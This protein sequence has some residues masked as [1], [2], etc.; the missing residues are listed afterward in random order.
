MI[1]CNRN[2]DLNLVPSY[3]S[4][5]LNYKII[6]I[7]NNQ[8]SKI[9]SF[10]INKNVVENLRIKFL[11]VLYFNMNQFTCISLPRSMN[12][13]ITLYKNTAF[14]YS[15][16]EVKMFNQVKQKQNILR[17]GKNTQKNCTKKIFM[18]QIIT[19]V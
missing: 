18:T 4:V 14:L 19:M 3:F 7:F 1:L 10:P 9:L 13:N 8:H 12:S 6:L 16:S 2:E 5:R 11:S 17:G 15:L